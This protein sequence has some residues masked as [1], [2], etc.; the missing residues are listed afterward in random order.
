MSLIVIRL[1]IGSLLPLALGSEVV[2]VMAMISEAKGNITLGMLPAM[3]VGGMMFFPFALIIMG[4][5]SLVYSLLMEFVVNP[6]IENKYVVYL[7]SIFLGVMS[8]CTLGCGY[9]A[10][11]GAVAGLL[12]GV[13]LKSIYTFDP[14]PDG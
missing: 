5:Q 4:I 11:V 1:L 14:Y 7:A 13:V 2:A 10:L 9:F 3:L 6:F 8:G 12:S